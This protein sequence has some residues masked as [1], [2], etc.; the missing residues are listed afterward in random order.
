MESSTGVAGFLV[1]AFGVLVLV[2]AILFLLEAFARFALQGIG[3]PAPVLPTQHLVVTGLNRYLRNPMYVAGR[4]L[5]D[6]ADKRTSSR[7]RMRPPH[8]LSAPVLI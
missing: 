6:A 3:T 5:W 2:T 1:P 4:D 7:R 8:S